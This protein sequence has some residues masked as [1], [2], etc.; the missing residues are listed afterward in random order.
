MKKEFEIKSGKI[1]L[2]DPCYDLGTWCQGV[3]DKV[4]NGVWVSEIEESSDGRISMLLSYH[5]DNHASF[6][7]VMEDGDLLNFD[8][9]VDSGHF[10]YDGY[11]D[12]ESMKNVARI[13]DKDQ[14]RICED[15]PFYSMCC[16][17][18]LSF[19]MWGVL[20]QGVVS[21]S[22]YGDGSYPTYGIK[23]DDGEYVAF[24]TIFIDPREDELDDDTDEPGDETG[25]PDE[26]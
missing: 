5:K 1:V 10:D 21:S 14:M 24:L 19:D 7:Y 25:E 4:K 11:R 6:E 12:D 26:N 16:D 23:N 8:G 18:T 13:A 2:S 22:G 20:P 9:G 3:I 15:E 17:R